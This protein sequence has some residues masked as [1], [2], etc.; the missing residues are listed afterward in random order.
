M[1]FRAKLSQDTGVNLTAAVSEELLGVT[2]GDEGGVEVSLQSDPGL[3]YVSLGTAIFTQSIALDH[4]NHLEVA[5]GCYRE[6]AE[7]HTHPEGMN[8]LAGL[9]LIGEGVR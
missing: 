5:C 8:R 3:F 6:A 9:L 1:A 7:V 4:P 2:F